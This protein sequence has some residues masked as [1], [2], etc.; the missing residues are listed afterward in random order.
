LYPRRQKASWIYLITVELDMDTSS[1]LLWRVR[2][3]VSEEREGTENR[4]EDK[5]SGTQMHILRNSGWGEG[6]PMNII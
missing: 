1:I 3:E 4:L 6:V 5:T 2:S